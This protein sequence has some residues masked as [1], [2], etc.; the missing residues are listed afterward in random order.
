MTDEQKWLLIFGRDWHPCEELEDAEGEIAYLYD[1]MSTAGDLRG[2]LL[3]HDPSR[4]EVR[5][6]PPKEENEPIRI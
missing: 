3:E 2:R 1:R 5:L 6:R 4:Y